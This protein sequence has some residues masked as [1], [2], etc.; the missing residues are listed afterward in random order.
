MPCLLK[1]A[2]CRSPF[3]VG[4]K[5]G[6]ADLHYV[7][8]ARPSQSAVG[9]VSFPHQT[10]GSGARATKDDERYRRSRARW[11]PG[12]IVAR[13]I[14][15]GPARDGTGQGTK[16]KALFL[17]CSVARFTESVLLSS[18]LARSPAHKASQKHSKATPGGGA[19]S[20]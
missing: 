10:P 16:R 8:S 18:L 6:S 17:A 13:R 3:P 2:K 14:V 12:R 19:L 15:V 11:Q 1:S 9:F 20:G 4:R 5:R 7:P